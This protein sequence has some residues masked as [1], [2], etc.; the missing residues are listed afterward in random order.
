MHPACKECG[1]ACCE[2][3]ALPLP[4]NMEPD[5]ARW[6][7]Y[8]GDIRNLHLRVNVTCDK[9]DNGQ[10]SIWDTRPQP[11]RDYPVGGHYCRAAIHARRP[12]DQ[13]DQIIQL[14]NASG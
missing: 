1:G 12:P 11:C 8:R 5:V 13:A 4:A 14:L 10:C 9:L 2:S 7:S 3:F 6:L